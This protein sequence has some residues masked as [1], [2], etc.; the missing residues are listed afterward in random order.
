[1][2]ANRLSLKRSVTISSFAGAAVLLG[3]G[4]AAWACIGEPIKPL[5]LTVPR[6]VVAGSQVEMTG[7]NWGDQA[8]QIR[9]GSNLLV[10][11]A[12]HDGSFTKMVTIPDDA[13]LG[14]FLINATEGDYKAQTMTEVVAATSTAPGDRPAEPGS[15][16]GRASG[17]RGAGA[18]PNPGLAP[19]TVA[20]PAS[21]SAQPVGSAVGGAVPVVGGAVPVVG[22][23]APQPAATAAPADAQQEPG[24]ASAKAPSRDLWSGFA[25][26]STR[27]SE[28]LV[29]LPSSSTAS[30]QLPLGAA[31]LVGGLVSM[32]AGFG[33]AE[34]RRRRA[35]A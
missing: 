5:G 33:L 32:L 12:P 2:R 7:E 30:S 10:V 19:D 13:A 14:P 29:K 22:G 27:P 24:A 23:A 31:V 35:A 3:A 1:M 6:Q 16:D 9:S 15:P 26:G 34:M 8:V 21:S 25:D 20:A 17:G 18:V 4:S 28:D 11:A